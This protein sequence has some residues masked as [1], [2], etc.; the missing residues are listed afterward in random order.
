MIRDEEI[1]LSGELYIPS[2]DLIA[3]IVE[4]KKIVDEF[5]RAD[6]T[7]FEKRDE[8]LRR[9]L[10]IEENARVFVYSPFYC[11]YG[12]HIHIGD[13]SFINH[14][15]I[16]LDEAN[17]FIGKDVRIAPNVGIYTVGHQEEIEPRRQGYEYA[18]TVT[19]EDN[20]WIGG[21]SCILPGV[22]IGENSI[23]GAGSVVRK[24]IPKNVVAAGNPCRV[25]RELKK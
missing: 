23:I 3:I 13:G 12:K 9:M 21:H 7:D 17:V 18:K 10:D 25:I 22:T 16:I 6:L 20:V 11:D 15:C 4:N 24:D 2:R 5:N 14:G 1:M 19:I 8:I